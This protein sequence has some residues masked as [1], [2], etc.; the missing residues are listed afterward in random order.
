MDWY[1]IKREF[2]KKFPDYLVYVI[3]SC[4]SEYREQEYRIKAMTTALGYEKSDRVSID[5]KK[6][7]VYYFR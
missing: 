4:I 7:R 6:K 5:Y 2:E 3:P 1:E